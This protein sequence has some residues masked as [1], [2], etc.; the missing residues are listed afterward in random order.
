MG[1]AP[2]VGMQPLLE[3]LVAHVPA[4]DVK[5][6]DPFRLCV[7]MIERDPFVGRLATGEVRWCFVRLLVSLSHFYSCLWDCVT[8]NKKC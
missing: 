6:D 3:T 8:Y 4:P 1:D 7:A 5:V 2:P